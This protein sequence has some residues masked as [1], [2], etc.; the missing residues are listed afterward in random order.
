M[1]RPTLPDDRLEA[2]HAWTAVPTRR[3]WR[4]HWPSVAICGGMLAVAVTFWVWA[5][6]AL[7]AWWL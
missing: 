2:F 4:I 7:V 3:R 5:L 6:S 1:T